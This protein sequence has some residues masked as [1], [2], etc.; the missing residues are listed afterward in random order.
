MAELHVQ[1]TTDTSRSFLGHP[2]VAAFT[3]KVAIDESFEVRDQS[4]A[5]AD[6]SG[7]AILSMPETD[8]SG[9]DDNIQLGVMAPDGQVLKV[10]DIKASVVGEQPI[11]YKSTPR[12]FF[13]RT[14][15]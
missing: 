14:Q 2:V 7:L 10:H 13:D 1:L 5:A 4:S 11:R 6:A 15:Y 9:K 12:S 8:S 3:R